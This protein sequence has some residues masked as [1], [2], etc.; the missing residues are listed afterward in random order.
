[1]VEVPLQDRVRE[2]TFTAAREQ[3]AIKLKENWARLRT[4]LQVTDN[5]NLSAQPPSDDQLLAMADSMIRNRNASFTMADGSQRTITL[6]EVDQKITR[7]P[8]AARNMA[9]SMGRLQDMVPREETLNKIA[10]ATTRGA[11]S[12]SSGFGRIMN[13]IRGFGKWIMS[14][15]SG[16]PM[17]LKE[18][19]A[20]VAAPR[21]GDSV[22][23]SL[24]E[25]AA[26]DQE[27]ARL[28]GQTNAQGQSMLQIVA[29]QASQATYGELGVAAPQQQ[30]G[31]P[32][33]SLAGTQTAPMSGLP[34]NTELRSMVRNRILNPPGGQSLQSTVERMYT[35]AVNKKRDGFTLG[36]VDPRRLALPNADEIRLTSSRM[37]NIIADTVSSTITD[38]SFRYNGKRLSELSREEFATAVSE[39]T[40][41]VLQAREGELGLPMMTHLADRGDNGRSSLDDIR[42]TLR[43]KLMESHGELQPVLQLVATSQ[44]RNAMNNTSTA[45]ATAPVPLVPGNQGGP[46]LPPVAQNPNLARPQTGPNTLV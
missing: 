3:V 35:D 1:M 43:Q 41:N 37:S 39:Q 42:D 28:L 34:S 20:S 4:L 14:K 25:L 11:Q 30:Q 33:P 27:A 44:S 46:N 23:Q 10:D 15:F 36:R 2:Q 29:Q 45:Q 16:N 18:A 6:E 22:T 7:L 21:V 8:D 24:Q 19:I 17:T 38:E 5:A 31:T 12:Q 13:A 40:A 26:N 9:S 32:A